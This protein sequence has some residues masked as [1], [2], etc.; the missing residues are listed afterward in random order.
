MISDGGAGGVLLD[1]ADEI[2]V[3]FDGRD[4][5]NKFT[6]RAE[7]FYPLLRAPHPLR[8][9]SRIPGFHRCVNGACR[10][11]SVPTGNVPPRT[12]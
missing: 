10:A 8:E 7:F 3:P 11:I 9:G 6:H 4:T 12:I 2:G 1:G 5:A